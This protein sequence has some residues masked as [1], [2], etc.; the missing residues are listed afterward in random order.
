MIFNSFQIACLLLKMS[1]AL[2]MFSAHS[3]HIVSLVYFF[4]FS[5]ISGDINWV[6]ST[7]SCWFYYHLK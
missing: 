5:R 1:D 2:S 3:Q 7:F 6:Y 4:L